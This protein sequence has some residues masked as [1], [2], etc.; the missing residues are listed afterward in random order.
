MRSSTHLLGK[1]DESPSKLDSLR[2]QQQEIPTEEGRGP[3]Q[4]YI[5]APRGWKWKHLVKG[6]YSEEPYRLRDDW[7]TLTRIT[8]LRFITITIVTG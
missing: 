4:E 7:A 5:H 6:P 8:L 2:A 1:P 3:T